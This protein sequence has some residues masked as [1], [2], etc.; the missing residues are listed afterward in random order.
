[1]SVVTQPAGSIC[2]VPLVE[3]R[4]TGALDVARLSVTGAVLGAALRLRPACLVVD[5]AEC[6]GIDAAAINMLLDAHRELSRA[7]SQLTLRAPTPRLRRILSIARVD[8]VLHTIP[9]PAGQVND[10]L[11]GAG[12]DDASA[13]PVP[14]PPA[15]GPTHQRPTLPDVD[16]P[17]PHASRR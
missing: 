17:R 16:S 14:D 15:G 11:P 4:I 5:L 9:G 13:R 2:S 7:G 12:G 6:S 3:I 10:R 8:H 1:M